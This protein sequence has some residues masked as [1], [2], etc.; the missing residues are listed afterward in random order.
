MFSRNIFIRKIQ[1][2]VFPE[3]CQYSRFFRFRNLQSKERSCEISAQMNKME[4]FQI[5]IQGE[6]VPQSPPNAFNVYK[7]FHSEQGEGSLVIQRCGRSPNGF[8]PIA[9]KNNFPQKI[10]PSVL[11]PI[12]LSIGNLT[13]SLTTKYLTG[14]LIVNIIGLAFYYQGIFRTFRRHID[15]NFG[16]AQVPPETLHSV[17]GNS[18]FLSNSQFV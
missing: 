12:Y 3:K 10:R 4:R 1:K 6:L 18:Q 9:E 14:Y 7:I 17:T 2:V 8:F 16:P 13:G 11:R 15:Q 5:F